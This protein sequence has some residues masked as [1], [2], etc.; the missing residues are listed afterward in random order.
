MKPPPAPLTPSGLAK[1][2]REFIGIPL[3]LR[4]EFGWGWSHQVTGHSTPFDDESLV[5][6]TLRLLPEGFVE[7]TTPRS[8]IHG[9]VLS[10]PHPY[11]LQRFV[12]FTMTDGC[13]HDFAEHIAPAWRVMLGDGT[14]DYESEWFPIL[15]GLDVYFGYGSIGVDE[16]ALEL[17]DSKYRAISEPR[18]ALDCSTTRRL[19]SGGPWLAA[20]EAERWAG[21]SCQDSTT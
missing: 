17:A 11:S 10:A 14:V 19:H 20:S 1:Q 8:G 15:K 12:A 7:F 18:P 2:C 9:T 3:V 4:C 6:G 13:E 16:H 21:S 5:A